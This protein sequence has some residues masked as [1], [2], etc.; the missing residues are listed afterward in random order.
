MSVLSV[1]ALMAATLAWPAAARA[2]SQGDQFSSANSPIRAQALADS[3]GLISVAP[4]GT[5]PGNAPSLDASVSD[6]GR[7]VAFASRATNLVANDTN[8]SSDIFVRDRVTNTTT[9][10]SVTSAGE[11]RQGDSV[12]PRIT[13][14]GRFVVFNSLAALSAD[15]TC[16][17]SATACTDVY[18]HDRNTSTTTKI[19]VAT[20]GAQGNDASYNASIS[21]DARYIAFL[22]RANNLVAADTNQQID[23]FLRDRLAATTTR[24]STNATGNESPFAFS[25]P[26]L[27]ADG[28]I[29][30]YSEDRLLVS[31]CTSPNCSIVVLRDLQEGTRTELVNLIPP[32]DNFGAV[33]H[34][35]KVTGLSADGNVVLIREH[36]P[37]LSH[38]FGP[39][40]RDVVLDR[41]TGRVTSAGSGSIPYN[42]PLSSLS[43]D[44]RAA[45]YGGALYQDRVNGLLDGVGW[46]QLDLGR[47]GPFALS[48]NGLLFA[49]SA[50]KNPTDP[51]SIDQIWTYDR[52][53]DKDGMAWVFE[54]YF[55]LDP[56]NAADATLDP[57]GDGLTNAQ[58]FERGSH[59]KGTFVRYFA[60]G[61]AN[62]FFS[63]RF[64]LLNPHQ[65]LDA[66]VSLRF[67][68]HNGRSMSRTSNIG[69]ASR[70]TIDI[71]PFG[72]VPSND[73][74]TV[75]ESDRPIVA[76]RTMTWD[77]TGY[78]GHSETALVS[79][80]TT[81]H[82][83]E[84][85]THGQFDLFYLLQNPNPDTAHVTVNYLRLAPLT[86]IV[87]TYDVPGNGRRTI[88][89]DDEGADLAAV[90]LAA[91][92]S[93]DL[94]IVA[95]RAMYSTRPG[96]QTFAAGHGG[97][98]VTAPATRWFLAE[99]ATGTFFDLYVLVSN[100]ATSQADI[101]VTYLLPSGDPFT[102]T[103]TVGP[104]NRLT[105]SVQSED[106]RLDNTPVSIIVESSNQPIIVERAMWWPKGQWHEAHVAAGATETGTRWGIAEA[107]VERALNQVDLLTETYLLI[108]N[109]STTDGRATVR[110]YPGYGVGT[111]GAV[112]FEVDLKASSRVSV[113]L[114]QHLTGKPGTESSFLVGATVESNGVE[115]VVERAMYKTVNG[116]PWAW[117]TAA[118][119]TKLQ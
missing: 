98:G 31:D 27:S 26:R 79:P 108:A 62:A 71:G 37:M 40:D 47:H 104:Q 4:D 8:T 68:G 99:G 95:E 13:P 118:L 80:S 39:F 1:S 42:P 74:A 38:G 113:P 107:E 49:F 25:S 16:A 81:W 73:F 3:I 28:R 90:D 20:G 32:P 109:T 119:A 17:P 18:L 10:V 54:I 50:A 52:D 21:A 51:A 64:A 58:E 96:Q 63:T 14:D 24:V 57:D 112:T 84:G 59:P 33:V 30:A 53:M 46:N 60:E 23:V 29:L 102:K 83:A 45:A 66:T 115:I 35:S 89:V 12:L 15:D 114:S 44:G 86:P 48:S 36:G 78:G 70:E 91:S 75:V 34:T 110:L 93:S 100:P 41:Q 2:Q 9:R 56:D 19:S 82:F 5:T 7:F 88:Y 22:S 43:N 116:V 77:A 55:D 105:I 101:T 69:P 97:A 6:N 106:P 87:K 85:A 111:A 92:I 61:A 11:E 103:Y 72:A 65:T 76:D 67:L 94:P 117:G